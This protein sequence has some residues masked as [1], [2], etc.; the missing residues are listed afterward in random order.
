MSLEQPCSAPTSGAAE[1]LPRRPGWPTGFTALDARL[2]GGWPRGAVSELLF[3]RAGIGELA[4]V[5]LALARL[6]REGRVAGAGGAAVRAIR[7]GAHARRGR[8]GARHRGR[9]ARTARCAVGEPNRRC[10]PAPAGR[11]CCGRTTS[12]RGAAPPAVGCRDRP[13]PGD[14]VSLLAPCRGE[15]AGGPAR[16]GLMEWLGDTERRLVT[17]VLVAPRRLADRTDHR[18]GGS[19]PWMR[20]AAGSGSAC[21]FRI[22]R[23]RCSRARPQRRAARGLRGQRTRA[24][25]RVRQR[26]GPAAR[27]AAGAARERGAGAGGALRLRRRDL[28]AERAALDALA[29]WAG[30]FVR[31]GTSRRR[32]RCARDRRQPAAVRRSRRC[33]PALDASGWPMPRLSRAVRRRADPAGRRLAG[34]RR[35]RCRCRDHRS[36]PAPAGALARCRWRC[37]PA[38]PGEREG[39]EAMGIR[40]VGELLRLPR[41][42]VAR[43]WGLR[44]WRSSIARSAA[45]RI[46]APRSCRRR[47]S[48]RSCCCRARSRTSRGWCS[49]CSASSRSC[50]ARCA[51]GSPA[52]RRSSLAAGPAPGRGSDPCRARAGGAEPRCRPSARSVPRAAG[53]S[54]LAGAGRGAAAAR[55]EAGRTGRGQSPTCSARAR[56]SAEAAGALIERLRARLGRRAVRGLRS[57]A[58]HRPERAF[59]RGE[60]GGRDRGRRRRAPVL[61][62]AEAAA[63]R[64]SATASRGSAAPW[65][66]EDNVERIESGWCGR[67]PTLRATISSRATARA[68]VT[69][70]SATRRRRD[71]GGRHG[72]F[73]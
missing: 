52:Y 67:A 29:A 58:E 31:C 70:C 42:G 11:C 21:I 5:V 65:N 57:V 49:R 26:R 24:A 14:A 8:S 62:A 4:L 1:P 64:D 25:N 7:A 35:C 69:G 53:A 39:F 73:G 63:A 17:A 10:A 2:A 13:R 16:C 54:E 12:S 47:A 36:G 23:S 37:S 40:R 61:A 34:A 60:P 22:S 66:L 71:S 33:S 38:A 45:C 3:A 32:R 51:R 72:V 15:L 6:S 30:Q 28:P 27:G 55:T 48:N 9:A 56:R 18:G 68:S 59:A 46:R 20:P 41:D 44:C 19:C 43:R 50:A